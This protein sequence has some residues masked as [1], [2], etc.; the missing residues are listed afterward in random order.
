[1]RLVWDFYAWTLC[2]GRLDAADYGVGLLCA[3]VKQIFCQNFFFKKYF[4][5]QN[6]FFKPKFFDLNKSLFLK[7]QFFI[8]LT[9]FIFK[10][11]FFSN[12]SFFQKKK[13]FL[14]KSFTFIK[15]VIIFKAV[16]LAL[17]KKNRQSRERRKTSSY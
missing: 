12:E 5:P 7:K 15:M 17:V 9:F 1:M 16:H 14:Q 3:R 11:T 13:F 6:L 4:S 10:T 2:L 8:F